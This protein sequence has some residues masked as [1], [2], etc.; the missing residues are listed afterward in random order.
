MAAAAASVAGVAVVVPRM[1]ESAPMISPRV[2]SLP[3]V[4]VVVLPAAVPAVDRVKR[5]RAETL[6]EGR[7]RPRA[8]QPVEVRVPPECWAKEETQALAPVGVGAGAAFT[9]VGAV[10]EAA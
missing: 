7:A 4:G 2:K 10:A 9:A 8:E 5:G 1:C 3:R 6:E